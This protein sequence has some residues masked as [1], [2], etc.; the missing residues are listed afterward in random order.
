MLALFASLAIAAPAA[1]AAISPAAVAVPTEFFLSLNRSKYSPGDP[2]RVKFESTDDG[3]LIVFRVDGDGYVRVL[4]PLDPDLDPFIRGGKQYELR[5]RGERE[6]FRADDRD[7]NGMVYAALSREPLD[8]RAYATGTH[9][10]YSRVRLSAWDADAEAELTELVRRMTSNGHF[11]Y[12]VKGYRV[13]GAGVYIS[14]GGGVTPLPV[15]P[16]YHDP[17]YD[18]YWSCLGC[19][20]GVRPG[21]TS[22]HFGISTGW[23]SYSRWDPWWDPWYYETFPYRYSPYGYGYG[24]GYGYN[25]WNYPG[26]YRPITVINLPRPQVP[27]NTA[28]GLRARPR[29]PAGALAPDLSLGARPEARPATGRVPN[30]SRARG[31]SDEPVRQSAPP[32]DRRTE[33]AAPAS[34]GRPVTSTTPPSS[35]GGSS[36]GSSSTRARTRR[37]DEIA[38]PVT[39]APPSSDRGQVERPTM[40]RGQMERPTTDRGRVERPAIVPSV[41]RTQVE[42]PQV[43]RPPVERREQET[44]ARRNEPQPVFREPF[45]PRPDDASQGRAPAERNASKGSSSERNQPV[46]RLPPQSQ[47]TQGQSRQTPPSRA[48][49]P[50]RMDPPSPPPRSEPVTRS[51]PPPSSPPAS[52][53][54][55]STGSSTGRAR[56]PDN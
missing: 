12:D 6:A 48:E 52:S 13:E 31:R 17:F 42:Q 56:R 2:V 38:A 8:L 5:G 35:A 44:P 51:A 4:F 16:G 54:S 22:I 9:W 41:G 53:G 26:Q 24:Y 19:G 49:A 15:A 39:A 37:P 46:Y 43:L 40:D 10:D 23:G 3:Y 11:T 25:N 50:R 20:Y 1:P 45:R 18:P 36:S 28:Y 47:S 55:G 32:A 33:R 7:G 27:T 21:G 34:A 30:D 14:G 29:T